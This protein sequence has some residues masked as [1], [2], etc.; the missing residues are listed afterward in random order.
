MIAYV[1]RRILQS[2]VALWIVVT[3][4]FA[5]LYAQTGS[6]ARAV[7]GQRASFAEIAAF[8]QVN[9]FDSP[10][11]VQYARFLGSLLRGQLTF[12]GPH[13]HSP[14]G[15]V[16]DYAAGVSLRQLASGPLVNTLVLMG[17]ALALAVPTGLVLGAWL[18]SGH[19]P[20]WIRALAAALNLAGYAIP[21]FV[22]GLLLTLLLGY[23]AG[24]LQFNNPRWALGDVF[25]SP[26][27]LV[28]PV[29]TL[30][31]GNVALFS[32]YF[33]ASVAECLATDYATKARSIGASELRILV[34]HVARNAAIP[35]VTLAAT[36]LPVIFGVQVPLEV[37]FNYPGIG[38][39]AWQA[40]TAKQSYTLLGAA[41]LVGVLV[42]AATFA[43]DILYLALDPRIRYGGSR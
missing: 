33:Q 15:I 30:A 42:V 18:G 19:G 28:L 37:F 5:M 13:P 14:Y 40:A 9:G 39:L 36:R 38:S 6:T 4:V 21:V 26:A 1:A 35:V 8:N 7:L 20:A 3:V 16:N 10:F 23:D 22:L 25:S 11:P 41:L 17:L 29:L 12:A 31:V 43:A 2:V 27:G 34:R 32:R 24:L